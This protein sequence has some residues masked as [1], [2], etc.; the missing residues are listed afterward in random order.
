M[1]DGQPNDAVAALIRE[2]YAFL[3]RFAY[4]LAGPAHD[5]EDLTQQA[6]LSA[7][8]HLDQLRDPVRARGWLVAI[9]RN[10]YRRMFRRQVTGKLL[11]LDDVAE[12]AFEPESEFPIDPQELARALADLPE[13][14]RTVIILYYQ[15]QLSYREIA[16]LL[17]LPIGTVMSRLSR[18]KLALR[19]KL[20]RLV[21]PAG[22]PG[23]APS[24]VSS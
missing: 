2:H 7:H 23:M 10:A 21:E 8:R 15:E 3:Y 18:G 20:S 22:I 11:A 24:T 13:D 6:F 12:P 1:S 17:E 5:A 14:F 19:E 4:R 16:E 9:L